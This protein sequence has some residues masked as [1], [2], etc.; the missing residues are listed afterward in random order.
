MTGHLCDAPALSLLVPLEQTDA[1]ATR[2]HRFAVEIYR[3]LVAIKNSAT[4]RHPTQNDE[5][6]KETSLSLVTC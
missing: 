2:R 4:N 5:R 3:G 1:L 6:E